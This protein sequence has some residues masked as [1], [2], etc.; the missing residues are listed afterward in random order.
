MA[1]IID[2]KEIALKIRLNLKEKVEHLK[3][4][5][6]NITLAVILVGDDP[7]SKIYVSNKKKA[8]EEIGIISKEYI[9]KDNTSEEDL[10]I[11]I[12][13]LNDSDEIDGILVQLPLPSHINEKTVIKRISPQ[14]DV[15]SFC[16]VNIGK[17][18]TKDYNFL[19]CTPAGI[20]EILKYEGREIKGKHCV[21][22]GRSN[23][24]GKPLALL[25]LNNDATVTVCHSKT[26]NLK[27]ICKMADILIVAIGKPKFLKSDMI[28]KDVIIIDVGINRDENSKL[29]GDVDFYDVKDK[30]SYITTVPGGVGPMTVAM[31]MDNVVTAGFS[32]FN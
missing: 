4:L 20:L 22:L 27:E 28:K 24:V 23:I 26:K 7:S 1:R 6:K 15:D 9:L 10:L 32:N 5:G 2:G 3:K 19:P 30:A 25:M 29:C 12:D 8:C 17:I 13:K 11:L 18:V 14:K 16:E 31:L 21:I